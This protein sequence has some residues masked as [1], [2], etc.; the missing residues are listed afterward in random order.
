MGVALGVA[1]LASGDAFGAPARLPWSIYL[2]N[3]YRQPSQ[4]YE[5]LGALIVLGLWRWARNR[6]P[7]PGFG[8]ILVVA[9]SAAASIFLEAFR[10]DSAI[11]T[12]GFRAPQLWGLLVLGACLL[13]IRLWG[14]G[15]NSAAPAVAAGEADQAGSGSPADAIDSTNSEPPATGMSRTL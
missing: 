4:I 14:R 2:W 3:A 6:L 7:A 11:V 12:G 10:G 8:I 1:H 9:A 13:L 15:S 5:I